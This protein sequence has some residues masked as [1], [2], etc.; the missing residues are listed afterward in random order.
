MSGDGFLSGFGNLEEKSCPRPP[1]QVRWDRPTLLCEIPH[2]SSEDG[3][4]LHKPIGFA[5]L[6][7]HVVPASPSDVVCS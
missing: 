7:V 4:G 3:Q 1:R 2:L 6:R 5:P